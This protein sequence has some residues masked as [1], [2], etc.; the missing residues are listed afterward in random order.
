MQMSYCAA[1]TIQVV[2]IKSILEND[3]FV[4]ESYSYTTDSYAYLIISES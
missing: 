4:V 1:K 2:I 3:G